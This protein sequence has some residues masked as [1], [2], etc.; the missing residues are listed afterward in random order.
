MY[1]RETQEQQSKTTRMTR[2]C[3]EWT[4][5]LPR[6]ALRDGVAMFMLVS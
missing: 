6:T 1:A 4:A 3:R 5:A 2:E